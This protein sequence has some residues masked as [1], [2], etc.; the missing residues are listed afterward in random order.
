[1]T[2]EQACG[3]GIARSKR[4]PSICQGGA[5]SDVTPALAESL[6]PKHPEFNAIHRPFH[7]NL[8][9]CGL[10]SEVCGFVRLAMPASRV[11]ACNLA[12]AADWPH[13]IRDGTA[14]SDVAG[15]TSEGRRALRASN[16]ASEHGDGGQGF[17]NEVKLEEKRLAGRGT[18]GRNVRADGRGNAVGGATA[19]PNA[20][21]DASG[22]AGARASARGGGRGGVRGGVR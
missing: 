20:E 7:T 6:P 21:S 17:V 16:G 10:S 15:S 3:R 19:E 13:E 4:D 18:G 1:M 8:S 2:N 12:S 11:D 14:A 9:P 22:P 5:Y